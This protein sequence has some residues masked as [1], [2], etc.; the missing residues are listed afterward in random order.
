MIVL[1]VVRFFQPDWTNRDV[2]SWK[3][4]LGERAKS[5]DWWWLITIAKPSRDSCQTKRYF[6]NLSISKFDLHSLQCWTIIIV[7]QETEKRKL[8]S[9]RWDSIHAS[10]GGTGCHKW[11]YKLPLTVKLM[12]T[13]F[14]HGL[15]D[16]LKFRQKKRE[17]PRNILDINTYISSVYG[18][19]MKWW[20]P[21]II[22]FNRVFHYKPSILGYPNFR[23][24]TP[25]TSWKGEK[26]SGEHELLPTY[27]RSAGN[28][29]GIVKW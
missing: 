21:Q 9:L 25:S 17:H 16:L 26:T 5:Q 19:F 11:P 13:E 27:F 20:Y 10:F 22:H 23:K 6:I 8:N 12:L 18:C 28:N 15:V 2:S 1:I 29:C 7:H 24:L 14:P 3:S 4:W